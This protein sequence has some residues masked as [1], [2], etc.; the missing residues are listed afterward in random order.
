ATPVRIGL[1]NWNVT[2]V[3]SGLAEG[4]PVILT[5][6]VGGMGDGVKAA[7]TAVEG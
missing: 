4:E 5:P 1:S 3:E 7:G 2:V 6:D